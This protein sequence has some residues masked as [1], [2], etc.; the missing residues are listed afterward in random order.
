MISYEDSVGYFGELI[1]FFE[2]L[3]NFVRSFEYFEYCVD[4]LED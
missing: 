4:C 1:N 2:S 3:G